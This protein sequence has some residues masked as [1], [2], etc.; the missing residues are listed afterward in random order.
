MNEGNYPDKVV[1]EA[2]KLLNKGENPKDVAYEL[3]EEYGY[4]R[5]HEKTVA[6]WHRKY[7]LGK[8]PKTLPP[9]VVDEIREVVKDLGQEE[10][11]SAEGAKAAIQAQGAAP[12]FGRWVTVVPDDSWSWWPVET[13]RR[14]PTCRCLNLTEARQCQKC[15][16]V[17]YDQ[18]AVS[19]SCS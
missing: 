10:F 19:S 13:V 5:L 16:A 1:N 8:S 4:A 7:P 9:R 11:L 2:V 6:R 17:L 3:R 12:S 14:C 15:D 18:A